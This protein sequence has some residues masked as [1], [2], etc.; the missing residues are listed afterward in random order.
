M[1]KGF[2]CALFRKTYVVI[3]KTDDQE[4]VILAVIHVKRGLDIFENTMIP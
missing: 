3:Y 1:A 2:R 4:V